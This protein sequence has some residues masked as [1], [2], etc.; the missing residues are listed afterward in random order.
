MEEANK[1]GLARTTFYFF[2]FRDDEKQTR[3][4]LLSSLLVQ[5]CDQSGICYNILCDLFSAHREGSREPSEGEL[6]RCLKNVVISLGRVPIYI[7][8]DALDECPNTF[9]IPSARETVLSVVRDIHDLRL[10]NLHICITSRPEPDIKTT[11]A[12][13]ASQSLSLHDQAGQRRDIRNYIVSVVNQDPTMKRWRRQ[14]KELVIE[15][16]SQRADGM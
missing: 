3:R 10:S 16:L 5:L 2:D 13:L 7:I 11:L 14:D 4:G 6:T 1:L 15:T 12:P 9:G 8:I